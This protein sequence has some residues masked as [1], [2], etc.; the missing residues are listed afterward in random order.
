MSAQLVRLLI[1]NGLAELPYAFMKQKQA[2][3]MC[4]TVKERFR[5]VNRHLYSM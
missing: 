1:K 2:V 3:R 4:T 5:E